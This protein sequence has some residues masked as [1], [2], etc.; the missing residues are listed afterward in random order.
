[1]TPD[2]LFSALERGHFETARRI[3]AALLAAPATST[4]AVVLGLHDALAALTEYQAANAL[5]AARKDLLAGSAF[6]VALRLAEDAHRLC[7]ETHYRTSGEA[8]QGLTLDEYLAKYKA[9][10]GSR[11]ADAIGMAAGLPERLEEIRASHIRCGCPLPP[12][13]AIGTA[14]PVCHPPSL[15][16]HSSP[17]ATGI[18]RGIIHTENGAPAAGI[19]VTLGLAP[20]ITHV[21]P[22][23]FIL[24][25]P[26]YTPQIGELAT[27]VTKTGSDGAFTFRDVPAGTHDFLSVAL[28]PARHAI[29]VR[30]IARDITIA[31]GRETVVGPLSIREWRSAPARARAS[32][33][34]DT[35]GSGGCLWKKLSDT[36]LDNPFH[37][38]FR[39]QLLRLPLPAGFDPARQSLR[40]EI[41]PGRAEPH[42]IIVAGAGDAAGEVALFV[43]LPARAERSIAMFAAPV[44]PE[45][46]PGGSRR[47]AGAGHADIFPAPPKLIEESPAIWQLDTGAAQF[48]IAGPGAAL[49]DAPILSARGADKCWRGSGRLRLPPGIAVTS[50]ATRV[51]CSG[52][53]LIEVRVE[54]RLGN[55]GRLSYALTAHAGEPFLAVHETT[56]A[57]DGASFDFSIPEFSGGRGFLHWTPEQPHG[58]RHWLDLERKDA[59]VARLPE[60]VPWW[61]PP[62]GFGFAVTAGDVSGQDYIGVISL[63]RGEWID[64]EFHR[65]SQGPVDMDGSE[66][67]ELD[68]PYP[69]MVGSSISMIT[70]HTDAGGDVYFRFGCFDGERRWGLYVSTL[71]ANEGLFKE[72]GALQ[73]AYSSPRLQEFKDWHFDEPDTRARPHVVAARD[74]LVS[75][76]AKRAGGRFGRLW[77]KIRAGRVP[78]PAAGLA[79]ALECDPVVAWKWR[80]NLVR[81]AEI[82]SRMILFGRDY[83][84][85]YSPVMGRPVTQWAE[86]YDLIAPSGV[87]SE[88]E[89]RTIRA[90]FILMGHMFMELDFMNWRFNARNANFE[91]DRADIVGAIGLVFDGHPDAGKFLDHVIALTKKSLLVYC[92]PGSGKWYE[93]PACYY[94]QAAKCRM[95]LVFHLVRRNRITLDEIPRLKDFLRWGIILLTP[96]SPVSYAIMRDGG[97][98]AV[99]DAAEKIRRIPPIGDH[100]SVGRWLPEFYATMGKLFLASDPEFGRELV[101]A[102]CAANADGFRLVDHYKTPIR[103]EGEQVFHDTSDGSSHGNLPLFFTVMEEADIPAAPPA[104]PLASR[105]LEGFGAVFRHSVNTP[106]ENYVLLKQGPGGYRFHRTEGS[107]VF[108]ANGRPL[109]YD[110]GEA[111]ET[112]RHSTLSFHDVHMPLAAG[113]LERIFCT[114]EFH[115]SQGVHPGAI[116]PGEPVFLSDSCGHELVPECYK[117]FRRQPPGVVR[118]LAWLDGRTLVIHDT[119]NIDAA[120]PSHWHLQVVG[121][122]PS[123][124]AANGYLFPGRFGIDL[125]VLFPGQTFAAASVETLPIHEYKG[126]PGEWFA[127]QHLCLAAP[128]ARNYLAVLHPAADGTV[129]AENMIYGSQIA[130]VRIR[131][132]KQDDRIWFGRAPGTIHYNDDG[133][134]ACE[135]SGASGALLLRE[136]HASLSLVGAGRLRHGG[137]TLASDGPGVLL[138]VNRNDSSAR[139]T[140]SGDGVIHITAGA[141]R[142]IPVQGAC[143]FDLAPWP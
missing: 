114:P 39:R 106:H 115:F 53:L 129:A 17:A 123:G 121:S 107:M 5:L 31:A 95:N 44:S 46:S 142:S 45:K 78:G 2:D 64:R 55:G 91:A 86:E 96:P 30:F 117:R 22:R 15:A 125:Q 77:E 35:L 111:G 43:A 119:I 40:V 26:R 24:E 103:Q 93:N 101:H 83:S 66:N 72:M 90:F 85:L 63:R 81:I 74:Q 108:F 124:D 127:M 88:E 49:M 42:Q 61:I 37:Y 98:A 7:S 102:Y 84:D 34:P 36:R 48:R 68:W 137:I 73:H 67:R 135:F 132:G 52:P 104:L 29:A 136:T 60:Q 110:G 99:Y 80:L 58:S 12:D 54:L 134:D 126:A 25:K 118:S 32:P 27:L 33:H 21:D 13:P 23:T 94:L 130:G 3:G 16:V 47:A 10:A 71:K 92:T 122:A 128:G 116:A 143:E 9:L 38:D 139:L 79:F 70:A 28:D 113:H 69:E 57:I 59:L 109:V 8:G 138:R 100:S 140:A 75:L 18:L 120:I 76:R 50:R 65:L 131:S 87:F 6:A 97:A 141:T 82:N 11:F 112:W 105:R 1:M 51:A 89:E 4:P 133:N 20:E 14:P 41:E 56:A 62:Q 19:A